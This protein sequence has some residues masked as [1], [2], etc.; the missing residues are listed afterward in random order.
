[1]AADAR[2]P[3]EQARAGR[4]GP[5]PGGVV[6]QPDRLA[7]VEASRQRERRVD[8]DP[9]EA[10]EDVR[11]DALGGGEHEVALGQQ[12]ERGRVAVEHRGGLAEGD[13]HDLVRRQGLREL[14]RHAREQG[15]PARALLAGGQ[16][17]AQAH[18]AGRRPGERGEHRGVLRGPLP[19]A[20][21]PDAERPQ[22]MPVRRS[23]GMA[24]PRHDA[25][26]PDRA[27]PAGAGVVAGIAHEQGLP[28]AHDQPAERLADGHLA[29]LRPGGIQADGA[30]PEGA[31]VVDQAHERERGVEQG[32]GVGREAVERLLGSRVEQLRRPDRRNSLG[33]ADRVHDRERS[34]H[35]GFGQGSA[36]PAQPDGPGIRPG[37]DQDDRDPARAGA[38]EH[39]GLA[40]G[41][42]G[43]QPRGRPPPQRGHRDAR[44]QAP[45]AAEGP[46]LG[47]AAGL[48]AAA[49]RQ[50]RP[51]PAGPQAPGHEPGPARRRPRARP[52]PRPRR[53]APRG[54]DHAACRPHARGRVSP[55]RRRSAGRAA[56]RSAAGR[57]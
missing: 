17:G 25:E 15:D 8:R 9:A 34:P 22:H 27:R 5:L 57:R 46:G 53:L 18:L 40:E 49:H 26:R 41:Q 56:V 54:V 20:R 37:S 24:G 7:G 36:R 38:G 16:G 35:G 44:D 50:R 1:M 13:A 51:P 39:E 29:P 11:A 55:R 2:A 19:R 45:A 43:A 32:R 14:G 30:L 48:R 31:A 10:R 28:V 42:P 12:G 4:A 23:D 52:C 6:G 33:V 21:V 3:G 47:G